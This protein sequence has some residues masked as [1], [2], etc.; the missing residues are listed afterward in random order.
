MAYKLQPISNT[1][2]TNVIDIFNYYVENGF[3][4]FPDQQVPYDVF[5]FFMKQAQ[6]YPT[7]S[8]KD[9]NAAVVF[10]GRLY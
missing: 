4:A 10:I 5:D 3:A 2:K 1:D 8:A 6:G 9:E 7:L